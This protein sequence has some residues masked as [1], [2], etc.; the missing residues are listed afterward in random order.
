VLENVKRKGDAWVG[1]KN[2]APITDITTAISKLTFAS[3]TG[4]NAKKGALGMSLQTPRVLTAA[5]VTL[6]RGGASPS[7]TAYRNEVDKTPAAKKAK[8]QGAAAA[9][10]GEV[11]RLVNYRKP[12]EIL[13]ALAKPQ[14]RQLTRLTRQNSAGAPKKLVGHE[15]W[16]PMELVDVLDVASGTITHQ[17]Y[18]WPWGSG[19]VFVH[20]T[21]E[22]AGL[23]IQHSWD[24]YQHDNLPLRRA[25]AAAYATAK[26]QLAETIDFQLDRKPPPAPGD[27]AK[28]LDAIYQ[29]LVKSLGKSKERFRLFEELTKEQQTV[30]LDVLRSAA[31][32]V[33]Q[34]KLEPLGLPPASEVRRWCGYAPQSVMEKLVEKWPV[35]RWLRAASRGEV[36][37]AAVIAALSKALSKSEIHALAF[38][39]CNDGYDVFYEAIKDKKGESAANALAERMIRLFASLVDT[40]GPSAAV[41]FAEFARL[42]LKKSVEFWLAAIASFALAARSR[43]TGQPFPS[44]YLPLAMKADFLGNGMH[45]RE[46]LRELVETMKPA[47]RET[48]VIGDNG[49]HF[50]VSTDETVVK[51]RRIE[52]P[53][54][55]DIWHVVDLVPTDKIVKAMIDS[56]G[57]TAASRTLSMFVVDTIVRCGPVCIPHLKKALK[58]KGTQRAVLA[59]A[60]KQLDTA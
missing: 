6:L 56:I 17:L 9:K 43:R 41:D 49:P 27:A 11:L 18:V 24:C 21:T 58:Q 37:D 55:L 57:P 38:A 8:Q 51:G 35:W 60:L 1:T 10:D 5:D 42:H 23:I 33:E 40:S 14:M 44:K 59:K 53:C 3:G 2:T 31:G 30:V 45:L 36:K 13:D 15:D 26:P 28:E 48:F 39:V 34:M 4:L 32:G 12:F 47:D 50:G 46:S 16:A 7:V 20:D 22:P 29:R 54:V 19:Q 52:V 25:L